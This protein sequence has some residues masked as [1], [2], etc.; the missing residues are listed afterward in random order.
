MRRSAMSLDTDPEGST[1]SLPRTPKPETGPS[2]EPISSVPDPTPVKVQES[3]EPL[4][5]SHTPS[6]I[7]DPTP[8][9]VQE[10]SEPLGHSHTPSTVQDDSPTKQAAGCLP[11]LL[12]TLFPNTWRN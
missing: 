2:R 1:K 9:K 10:S 11:N 12:R 3:S 6:T 7:P 4:G 8:V 5:H